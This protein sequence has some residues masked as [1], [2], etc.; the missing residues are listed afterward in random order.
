MARL[1]IL[2]SKGQ[3]TVE[4]RSSTR[5]GRVPGNTVEAPDMY[6]SKYHCVIERR[7]DDFWLRDLGSVN[8]THINDERVD[9]D[10][11]LRHNDQ[12]QMGSTWAWFDDGRGP[13]VL[14]V[15]A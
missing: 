8:G 7:D 14:R 6:M 10:R 4:L 9:E 15:Y 13:C 3:R 5:I 2:S 12:I 11:L 1:I